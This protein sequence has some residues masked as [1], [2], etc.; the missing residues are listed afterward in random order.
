VLEA[1][2]VVAATGFE[3]PLGDLPGLGVATVLDGRLPALTPLFE[4]V[5]VPGVFFA[6]NVTQAAQGLRKHG[7]ASVSSMVCGFRYNARVLARH[8]AETLFGLRRE[9]PSVEPDRVVS[10][11]LS[12][13]DRA[14]E[15]AMQKG[16]L[17][18]VLSAAGGGLWDEGIL[19]LEVFV[20]GDGDGVAATLE[21]DAEEEI[22]PVLYV[23]RG[24]LLRE[25]VLPPH[26]LRR[27]DALVYRDALDDLLRPLLTG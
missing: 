8:L 27:Y 4:S 10:Y 16:Y 24:G 23:R 20:D 15:L 21:F 2:E 25:A 14:P 11:L 5:T 9:R 1:D 19:P 18:R 22:R 6:G 13:L 17:A 12:E 7:V 26:P 3:A